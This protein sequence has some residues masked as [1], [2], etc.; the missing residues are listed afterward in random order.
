MEVRMHHM[1]PGQLEQAMERCSTLFLPLGTIEWHGRHNCVGLD[2]VKAYRLC[3]RAAQQGGGVVA[4]PV[5]GG[6]GGLN[7][8]FTFIQETDGNESNFRSTLVRPWLERLCEEAVRQGFRAILMI[9]GHYGAEQQIIVRE[10]AV[11]MTRILGRPVL[12]TPEYFLALD[13]GYTGDHAAFFETSLMMELYPETVKLD[14]LGEAPH[15]GVYGRDP[16]QHASAQDGK[17]LADAIVGRLVSLAGR[18]HA[19]DAATVARFLAAEDALVTR[20]IALAAEHRN[21]W[22]AWRHI[23]KSVFAPYPALLAEGRFEE[24]VRLV[25]SL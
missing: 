15:Q 16:K 17:R 3:I 21:V 7:E 10:A 19:W 24:I 1:R 6:M 14:E 4:P 5:Y 20:Q 23:E 9:T 12:G 11:R 13:E 2:A 22:A 8:P 25:E 18:M